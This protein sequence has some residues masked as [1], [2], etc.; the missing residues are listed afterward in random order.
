VL[1]IIGGVILGAIIVSVGAWYIV[2]QNVETPDYTVVASDGAIEI[3]DYP[4]LVVAE[5]RRS[6]DR[7]AAASAGFRPLANYIFAKDRAGGSISMTAPVTQQAAEEI[8]MT[9][10]VTQTPDG[11]EWIVRFIMPSKYKLEALPEPASDEV[12]LTRIPAERR[13]A[14]RFS[15]SWDDA[16]FARKTKELREWLDKR[17]IEPLGPPTYAYYNDPFTPGFLR[18]NEVM[19]AI[20]PDGG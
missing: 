8:A 14:I 20:P 10:P 13:A 7:Q 2:T 6:G 18:R 17:G 3:R 4:P 5:V 12:T 11:G 9:A 19:F 1:W 16:L 15:G